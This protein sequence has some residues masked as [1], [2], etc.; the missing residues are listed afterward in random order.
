MCPLQCTARGHEKQHHQIVITVEVECV[1]SAL[2]EGKMWHSQVA[3]NWTICK[4]AVPIPGA[5]S[6]RQAKEAAGPPTSQLG[7]RIIIA[8]LVML[9]CQPVSVLLVT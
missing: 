6:A 5:K 8:L 7:I 1:K 3:I 2:K 9:D 4:G